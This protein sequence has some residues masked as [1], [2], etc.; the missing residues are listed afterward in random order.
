[1]L[2]LAAPP[3]LALPYCN[4]GFVEPTVAAIAAPTVAVIKAPTAAAIAAPTQQLQRRLQLQSC[5]AELIK[6]HPSS[7]T[8]LLLSLYLSRSRC[9][10]LTL[11]VP[12]SLS[13]HL[14]LARCRASLDTGPL[15]LLGLSRCW[16][17]RC[18]DSRCWASRCWASFALAG[19]LTL[20]LSRCSASCCCAFSRCCRGKK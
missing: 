11:A 5:S 1:M 14:S 2:P 13:L 16:A 9:A 4:T 19:P 15:S 10:S 7:R 8:A 18:W 6:K 17:S 12:L 3:I 20:C